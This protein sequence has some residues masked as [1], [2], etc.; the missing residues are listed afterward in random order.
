MPDLQKTDYIGI[1]FFFLMLGSWS[2]VASHQPWEI[3]LMVSRDPNK[4]W[5]R[6]GWSHEISGMEL[7][8]CDWTGFVC[9]GNFQIQSLFVLVSADF[10]WTLPSLPS[11]PGNTV[12]SKP[13]ADTPA[14][15]P[16]CTSPIANSSAI[17]VYMHLL[18]N[19]E[20]P[21]FTFLF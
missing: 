10:N 14:T 20:M 1:F 4:I 19:F 9:S 3:L 17:P 6:S 18:D 5:P 16:V 12:S 8:L 13:S 2:R 7:C 15:S 11:Q 21:D